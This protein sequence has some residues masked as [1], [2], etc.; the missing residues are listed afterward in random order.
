MTTLNPNMDV[1]E[2]L[3]QVNLAKKINEDN[4]KL[5][6]VFDNEKNKINNEL[7]L[8]QK[9]LENITSQL[10]AANNDRSETI[11]E[12]NWIKRFL[13]CSPCTTG[14]P[15]DDECQGN[16]KRGG[17]DTPYAKGKANESCHDKECA[18]GMCCDTCWVVNKDTLQENDNTIANIKESQTRIQNEINNKSNI[19]KDMIPPNPQ[20]ITLSCCSNKIIAGEY[21][22]N[23]NIIQNCKNDIETTKNLQLVSPSSLTTAPS[24]V[25]F[26]SLLKVPLTTTPTTTPTTTSTTTSTTTPSSVS[27]FTTTFL[28]I[29]FSILCMFILLSLII[30]PLFL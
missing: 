28:Y 5:Q 11:D 20:P 1:N 12:R 29:S 15:R 24:I 21:S 3:Q 30:I 13:W 14:R 4:L 19:L 2:C 17:F 8:K 9:E 7:L 26:T 10:I 18:L 16:D 27:T 22:K 25:P 6:Q 23:D